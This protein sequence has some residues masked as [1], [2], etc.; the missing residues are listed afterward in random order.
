MKVKAVTQVKRC[1]NDLKSQQQLV[2]EKAQADD[3]MY[4]TFQFEIGLAILNAHIIS[5]KNILELSKNRMY[6]NWLRV[7]WRRHEKIVI[8]YLGDKDQYWSIYKTKMNEMVESKIVYRSLR[9]FLSIIINNN[10]KV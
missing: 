6:W 2:M 10:G 4:N 5:D 7:E 8:Q 3:L 9:N 1:K